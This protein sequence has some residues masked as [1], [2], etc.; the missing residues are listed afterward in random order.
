[1]CGMVWCVMGA[2]VVTVTHRGDGHIYGTIHVSLIN[3]LCVMCLGVVRF[4]YVLCVMSHKS[5][6]HN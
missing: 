2:R 5:A 6:V 4:I 1:V 3:V